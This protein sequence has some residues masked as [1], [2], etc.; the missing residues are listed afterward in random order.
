MSAVVN[1]IGQLFMAFARLYHILE[2]IGLRFS[3]MMLVV[4]ANKSYELATIT[5]FSV[6][7]MIFF[8]CI[9]YLLEQQKHILI[10]LYCTEADICIKG[11]AVL[12]MYFKSSYIVSSR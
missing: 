4:I 12:H 2:V 9:V 3:K 6:L 7:V 10:L 8:M 11:I 5:Y 1:L